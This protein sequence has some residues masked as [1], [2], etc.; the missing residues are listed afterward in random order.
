MAKAFT[1]ASWNVEH[2]RDNPERITRVVDFLKTQKPDVFALLEVEGASVFDE[3]VT[4]M[5]G[6]QFHITEGRQTQEV[7]V[8]VKCGLTGFFTQKTEFR[9]GEV[10]FYF[11]R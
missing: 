1:L 2:F 10:K 8:G 3:L 5:P 4:R 11:S 9:T 7:L 6:Y